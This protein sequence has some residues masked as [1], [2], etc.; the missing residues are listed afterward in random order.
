MI[1]STY[2]IWTDINEV[3]AQYP[4]LDRDVIC[5]VCVVGGGITGALCA[6]RLAESGLDTVLI[7]ENR[8]G[9]GATASTMPCVEYDFGHTIHSLKKRMDEESAAEFIKMG[10]DAL[11]E[12]S[13]LVETLD[14]DCGFTLRD[15]MIFTDDASELSLLNNEFMARRKAGFDCSYISR[16]SARDVFSFDIAGAIVSKGLAA[17]LDPYR[18]AHM[19]AQ[20]ATEIGARIFENTKAEMIECDDGILIETSTR[21]LISA[22]KAVIAGGDSCSQIFESQTTTK[23]GFMVATEPV[24]KIVG[25]PGRCV[26]RTWGN[27]TVTVAASPDNRICAGGL[28]TAAVDEE[29]RL[30]GII[31]IH[32][33]CN[34]RF[35]ELE[36]MPCYLFPETDINGF[37]FACISKYSETYDRLPII[38]QSSRSPDC[39][40]ALCPAPNAALMSVVAASLIT[41]LCSGEYA[42]EYELFSPDR[43]SLK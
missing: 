13:H 30:Y 12:L 35:Q 2:P 39:F 33:L 20:R 26:I 19:C 28:T 24:E 17:E 34:R 16:S 10:A 32:K 7:T 42:D 6:L 18:L 15:S 5:D 40:F 3:P 21:R 1:N 25:W 8:I 14:G 23:T 31:P 37:E 4:W 9:S 22:K 29:G 38:G 36:E 43:K 11:S 41:R 27:P